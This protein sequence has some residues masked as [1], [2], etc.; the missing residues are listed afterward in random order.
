MRQRFETETE[1]GGGGSV[2]ICLCLYLAPHQ[3]IVIALDLVL[4]LSLVSGILLFASALAMRYQVPGAV[5]EGMVTEVEPELVAVGARTG[6]VR[7]PR[8]ISPLSR[9]E[10]EDR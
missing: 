3:L 5:P 10:L 6:T 9:V 1:R 8:K 4:L 7:L 2:S